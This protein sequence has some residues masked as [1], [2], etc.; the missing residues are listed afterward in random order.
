MVA[1]AV[2]V[3]VAMVTVDVVVAVALAIAIAVV[4]AAAGDGASNSVATKDRDDG[5]ES[6]ELHG[7]GRQQDQLVGGKKGEASTAVGFLLYINAMT[8]SFETRISTVRIKQNR[9]KGRK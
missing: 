4:G 7:E 1:M 8:S 5:E 2:A 6:G 9:S 3:T